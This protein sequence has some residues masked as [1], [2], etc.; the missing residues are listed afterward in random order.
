MLQTAA[1]SHRIMPIVKG[2]WESSARSYE[3]RE[4]APRAL[5]F[6]SIDGQD[7]LPRAPGSTTQGA[8]Q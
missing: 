7:P 5:L 1:N 3:T 2:E 4:D 8:S 6:D